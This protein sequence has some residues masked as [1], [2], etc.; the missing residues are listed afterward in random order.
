MSAAL[1]GV[2]ESFGVTKRFGPIASQ[3]AAGCFTSI[4][5]SSITTVITSSARPGPSRDAS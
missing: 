2:E 4:A 5:V 1:H 3:L